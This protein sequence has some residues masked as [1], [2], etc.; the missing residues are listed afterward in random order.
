MALGFIGLGGFDLG[1]VQC[2]FEF[3]AHLVFRA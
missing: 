2:F 1:V 3:S